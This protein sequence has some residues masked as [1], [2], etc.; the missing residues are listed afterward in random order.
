MTGRELAA[1]VRPLEEWATAIARFSRIAQDAIQM[2]A[3]LS[4]LGVAQRELADT[5]ARIAAE[6]DTL[7]A[8]QE[9]A[10][11]LQGQ[12]DAQRAAALATTEREQAERIRAAQAE[13]AQARAQTAAQQAQ[14]REAEAAHAAR[15]AALRME[16]TAL[17]G[18]IEELRDLARRMAAAAAAVP[19]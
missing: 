14:T 7:L 12:L 11:R 5:K 8:L 16:A 9:Q 13:I 3:K 4:G 15:M 6:R 2:E 17:E 18:R 10:Q 1:A 19:R